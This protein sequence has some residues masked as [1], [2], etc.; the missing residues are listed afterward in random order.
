MGML[1]YLR[2]IYLKSS[3]GL[4]RR[5]VHEKDVFLF[6]DL[7]EDIK[8]LSELNGLTERIISNTRTLQKEELLISWQVSSL[9]TQRASI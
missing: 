2:M 6:S 1:N 4:K 8:C 3:L 7:L 9:F 5:I